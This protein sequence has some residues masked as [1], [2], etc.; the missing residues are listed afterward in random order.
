VKKKKEVKK[1]EVKNIKKNIKNIEKKKEK[2]EEERKK[3]TL[4]GGKVIFGLNGPPK[5]KEKLN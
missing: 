4:V 1:K 2:K 5:K 3:A